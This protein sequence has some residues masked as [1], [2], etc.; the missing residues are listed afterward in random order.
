MLAN[1]YLF[2]VFLGVGPPP[3][4]PQTYNTL[5]YNMETI[6]FNTVGGCERALET[7][8]EAWGLKKG[9]FAVCLDNPPAG[10]T[11]D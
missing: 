11:S 1:Y 7:I 2:V 10:L 5:T 4:D 9:K 3:H 8:V 6:G